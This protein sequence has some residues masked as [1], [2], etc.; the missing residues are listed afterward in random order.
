MRIRPGIVGVVDDD[1]AFGAFD[2]GRVVTLRSRLSSDCG[3][4]P[5]FQGQ[6]NG[7]ADVHTFVRQDA[8]RFDL[9]YWVVANHPDEVQGVKPYVQKGAST[10][11]RTSDA[12]QVHDPM[13]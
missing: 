10:E 1:A 8:L 9:L 13:G 7:L 2:A 6:E 11:L 12:G 4:D 5:S 3:E